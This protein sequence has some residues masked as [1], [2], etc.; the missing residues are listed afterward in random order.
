M[1]SLEVKTAS[2][3]GPLSYAFE[4]PVSIHG[5]RKMGDRTGNGTSSHLFNPL[6][7]KHRLIERYVKKAESLSWSQDIPNTGLGGVSCQIWSYYVEYC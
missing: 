2:V 7:I 5:A 4:I 3:A 6:V 1:L